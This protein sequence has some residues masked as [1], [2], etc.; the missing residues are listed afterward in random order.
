MTGR[1]RRSRREVCIHAVQ[2]RVRMFMLKSCLGS[3]WGH[4]TTGTR[5][6]VSLK[7]LIG[8][9]QTKFLPQMLPI[10]SRLFL[11]IHKVHSQLVLTTPSLFSAS[12][13]PQLLFILLFISDMLYRTAAYWEVHLT[14][15]LSFSYEVSLLPR[16]LR[17]LT[18]PQ[19][20]EKMESQAFHCAQL[21][22]YSLK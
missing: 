1:Q 5:E 10:F 16:Y 4:W 8:T 13:S 19:P 15:L 20:L 7:S 11:N 3:H 18:L 14:T 2:I 9:K 12:S 17:L 21:I 6:S 22:F